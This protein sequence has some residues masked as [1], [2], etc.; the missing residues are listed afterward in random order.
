[1]G[2]VLKRSSRSSVAAHSC[3][4]DSHHR[5]KDGH[6]GQQRRSVP[7]V[8]GLCLC[9]KGR[10]IV[11]SGERLVRCLFAQKLVDISM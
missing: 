1:M 5:D 2:R 4:A 6:V 8:P 7:L 9:A 3:N 11:D 10:S